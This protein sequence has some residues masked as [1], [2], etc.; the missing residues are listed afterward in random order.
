MLIL[1]VEG[2]FYRDRTHPLNVVKQDFCGLFVTKHCIYD[3]TCEKRLLFLGKGE[4]TLRKHG[5]IY[6]VIDDIFI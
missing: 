3:V 1:K 4:A 5:K 6:E 2:Q